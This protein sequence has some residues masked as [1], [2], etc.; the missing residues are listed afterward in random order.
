MWTK[1]TLIN[2][3]EQNEKSPIA[4]QYSLR[5]ITYIESLQDDEST[6]K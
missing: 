4:Q 3:A 6:A 5:K 2:I 1:L